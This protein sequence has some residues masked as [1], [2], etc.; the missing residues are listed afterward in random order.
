MGVK[1]AG[2]NGRTAAS[3]ARKLVD[4][5]WS[6]NFVLPDHVVES[7]VGKYCCGTVPALCGDG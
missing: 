1:G 7:N 2:A 3:K 5:G 4:G 6:L